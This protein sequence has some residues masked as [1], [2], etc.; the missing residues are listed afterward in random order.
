MAFS[1][2]LVKSYL[3]SPLSHVSVR[4]YCHD[5]FMSLRL[6][7]GLSKYLMSFLVKNDMVSIPFVYPT[8]DF[9][10]LKVEQIRCSLRHPLVAL[11]RL[12]WAEE[13]NSE[14]D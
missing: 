5:V 12:P 14:S 1:A 4:M 8:E 9:L 13:F 10:I 3:V 2:I 11:R 7:S 6:P